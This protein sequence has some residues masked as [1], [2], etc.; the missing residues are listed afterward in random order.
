MGKGKK[1]NTAEQNEMRALAIRLLVGFAAG[2]VILLLLMTMF[3]AI[4][5]KSDLNGAFVYILGL[6]ASGFAAMQSG[7][8]VTRPFHKKGLP[9]GVMAS[10]PL[11][12]A[13]CVMALIA[14]NG[15]LG[16]HFYILA[17]VMLLCGALG[18]IIAA[19]LRKFR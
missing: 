16:A 6:F 7:F 2:M 4:I 14:N 12:V 13:V 19:N 1:K 18:G 5:V 10:L 17:A 9:Y 11:I 15:A 8:V 3:A